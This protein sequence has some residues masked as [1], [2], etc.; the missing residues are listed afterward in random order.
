M[1]A[2]RSIVEVADLR[3]VVL[4]RNEAEGRRYSARA[5]LRYSLMLNASAKSPCVVLLENHR[6]SNS[7]SPAARAVRRHHQ[8]CEADEKS[9]IDEMKQ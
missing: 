6:E 4:A 1:C 8:A 2:P 5:I 3:N 9:L 7:V